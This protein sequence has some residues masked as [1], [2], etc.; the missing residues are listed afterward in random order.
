VF[1]DANGCSGSI[2]QVVHVT[3]RPIPVINIIADE[4]ICRGQNLTLTLDTLYDSYFWNTGAST[5]SIQAGNSGLYSVSVIL[6]GC[7]GTRDKDVIIGYDPPE[8]KLILK[9]NDLST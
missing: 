7:S 2:S 1:T 4:V 9:A 5:S 6:N 3:P 8:Q